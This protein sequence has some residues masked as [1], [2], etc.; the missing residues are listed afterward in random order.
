MKQ[1]PIFTLPVYEFDYP[2][3]EEFK[4]Q[5][6]HFFDTYDRYRDYS[7]RDT[8]LLTDSNL[9]RIPLFKDLADFIYES[10]NEISKHINFG[11]TLKIT[12]LWGTRHISGGY[13]HMH[14]HPNSLF[15]GVYYLHSSGTGQ[16]S[17]TAFANSIADFILP[18]F[19][20]LSHC[21]KSVEESGTSIIHHRHETSW[22]EGRLIVFP[23]FLRHDTR[24]NPGELRQVLACNIMPVGKTDRN[25][26][27]RYNFP[28][29]DNLDLRDQKS[30]TP[31]VN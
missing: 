9:H 15:G 31:L 2:R 4:S 11:A 7:P 23:A 10:A 14:S 1:I 26:Y 24:R 18:K 27:D 28:D 13:H 12:G 22:K 3:H 30:K 20:K 6:M 19:N 16:T 29:P 5:Y 8:L 17:G 25:N 21:G